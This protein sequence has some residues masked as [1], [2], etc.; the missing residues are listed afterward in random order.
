MLD[1]S[2]ETALPK[3]YVV[4]GCGGFVG[5]HYLDRLLQD[6]TVYVEGFDIDST[7]IK[8]HLGKSN[9]KF[10]DSCIHEA[11]NSKEL[12][13][14]I[15]EADAVINLAAICNPSQYNT[16]PVS[17]IRHNCFYIV[18]VI[19]MC[20]R[21][22]KW[23]F[24]Y[25]TSEV[26][27]R[28]ISS[29]LSG[30]DY[31]NLDLY[32]QIEDTTPLLM[33]PISNQRWSYA[34]SKQL[35]ER[36]IYALSKEEGLPFTVIRPFNYFG[37]RMDFIPGRDGEGV[38]RVLACF[39][40]ALLDN[41][42]MK[43]VDQGTARRTITSIHDAIEAQFLAQARPDAAKNQIFN[44]ANPES[45]VTIAELAVL[46]RDIFA[47]VAGDE[48]K[49]QHPIELVTGAEFYGEGYEDCDRRVA[50]ISKAENLLGWKPKVDLRE[51]LRE[52][53]TYYWKAYGRVSV[54]A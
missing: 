1:R 10:Y 30:D 12:E 29:Y 44:I 40:K 51:T 27:G 41:E 26:Y 11:Q 45:E 14:A 25:S 17:V 31:S 16:E 32:E 53:I 50:D 48:S 23:L 24:H 28:T 7:K 49:K 21:H 38:P 13:N 47:E 34:A 5:S 4:L 36:Y 42:P 39:M 43:L 46:M 6:E 3:R 2:G 37:P 19:D 9:F 35:I 15:A 8:S 54:A 52:T 18:P 33:G 22:N 20:V